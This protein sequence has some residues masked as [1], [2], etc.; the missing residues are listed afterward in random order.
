MFGTKYIE[1]Y[2]KIYFNMY[3]L[4]MHCK[5][6]IFEKILVTYYFMLLLTTYK[7]VQKISFGVLCNNIPYTFK[8]L[9]QKHVGQRTVN[10]HIIK[11]VLSVICYIPLYCLI[12]VFWV[13]NTENTAR[14]LKTVPGISYIV[15]SKYFY[16]LFKIFL[17]PVFLNAFQ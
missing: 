14:M 12:L 15:T 13:Y 7:K 2:F 4:F 3:L 11:D 1:M 5:H 17:P 8:Y 6:K 16:I 9:C 10:L